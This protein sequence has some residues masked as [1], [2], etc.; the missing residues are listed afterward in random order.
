MPDGEYTAQSGALVNRPADEVMRWLTMPDLMRKWILGA[1]K[2]S[3]S[4]RRSWC[5]AISSAIAPCHRRR[6]P[7]GGA[8]TNGR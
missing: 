7:T 4:A 2:V 5:A 1:D 8:S 6:S 3:S